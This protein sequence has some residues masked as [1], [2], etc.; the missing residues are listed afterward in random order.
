MEVHILHEDQNRLVRQDHRP[1][2]SY[3]RDLHYH[4]GQRP[5]TSRL[6]CGLWSRALGSFLGVGRSGGS[7]AGQIPR[8]NLRETLP[9]ACEDC[10]EDTIRGGVRSLRIHGQVEGP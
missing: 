5:H 7:H 2:R 3:P 1:R 6:R 9:Q 4:A 10:G 8:R